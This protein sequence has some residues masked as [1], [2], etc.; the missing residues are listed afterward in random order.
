MLK[1]DSSLFSKPAGDF[2]G[3]S[4]RWELKIKKKNYNEEMPNRSIEGNL[5][6]IGPNDRLL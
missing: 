1:I 5:T 3:I 6:L 2:R 4:E